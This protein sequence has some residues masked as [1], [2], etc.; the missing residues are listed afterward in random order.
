MEELRFL[1]VGDLVE[2]ELQELGTLRN[3]VEAAAPPVI[4]GVRR[5]VRAS[6]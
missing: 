5:E 4:A 6:R 3:R 1:A 2:L